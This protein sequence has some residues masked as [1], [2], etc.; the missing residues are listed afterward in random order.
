M[1]GEV[2]MEKQ[3]YIAPN[4]KLLLPANR[5]LVN[6]PVESNPNEDEILGKG[7][8]GVFEDDDTHAWGRVWGRTDE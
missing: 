5:L 7:H 8:S 4:C 3:T 6:I 2:V 1:K